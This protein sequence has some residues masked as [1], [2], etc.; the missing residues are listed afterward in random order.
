LFPGE[1]KILFKLPCKN[2]TLMPINQETRIVRKTGNVHLIW[3]EK[4]NSWIRLE[5]PA[6]FIYRQFIR[7]IKD[8][9]IAEKIKKRYSLGTEESKE[10][11]SGITGSFRKYSTPAPRLKKILTTRDI[12]STEAFF[13]RRIYNFNNTC[14]EILYGSRQLE[15]M[16]HPSF[17]HLEV[18]S[19]KGT[20]IRIKLFGNSGLWVMKIKNRVWT[21]ENPNILK[22]RL[23][24]GISGILYRKNENDWLTIIH[25]S[26]V[27]NEREGIVLT[28]TAGSGKS[29]LAAI[30]CSNGFEFVSDDF[31]AV[32]MR[33]C[34]LHPFP[35]SLAVKEGSYPVLEPLFNELKTNQE[36]HFSNTSKTVK[37]ISFPAGPDFYKPVPI[38]KII[39]VKFQTGKKNQ[40]HQIP[41]LE[42]FKRFNDEAWVSPF[43]P[44]AKKFI[45][46]FEQLSCYE[47]VYSDNEKAVKS[48]IAIMNN[49]E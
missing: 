8:S 14:L 29:T 20:V 31:V 6:W 39:F 9:S 48:I 47:M 22:R 1:A 24:I 46:W 21:E 40:L 11:V 4:S 34:S 26:A 23:F 15:Y 36:F 28:M 18:K 12:K 30:L 35:A 10:F 41:F 5:E 19:R 33:T 2:P 3:F 42:A 32:D 13:S 49:P 38:R 17:A 7:G 37:Y 25:G 27:K 45:N 44:G 16:V 43:P